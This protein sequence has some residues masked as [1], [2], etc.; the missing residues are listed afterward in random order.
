MAKKRTTTYQY[1]PPVTP[2][3]WSGDEQRYAVR[4]TQLFD[5]LYQKY[6]KLR[7]NAGGITEETDP[8]VPEW[9][10]QENPPAQS[11]TSVN[12]K[13]GAVVL[14]AND[15][16]A[17]PNGFGLGDKGTPCN[18]PNTALLAGWYSLSGAGCI[19]VPNHY[20]LIYGALFVERRYTYIFQTVTFRQVSI[21][22]SSEDGGTT[23][24]EWEYVSPPLYLGVEYPTTE[25][26]Y[27]KIV[28]AKIVN[29]GAL[30]NNTQ[31]YVDGV[32]TSGINFVIELVPM[33]YTSNF[34][35][36]NHPNVHVQLGHDGT[37]AW[38][39]ITTTANMSGNNL[40]V[41][42]KWAK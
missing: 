35:A 15:V 18:D 20:N 41:L 14:N 1:E 28:Y 36:T 12:D 24:S 10:K 5:D 37:Y 16:G 6:G 7:Q 11:V 42:I 30:P 26:W 9:A 21:K 23:W 33:I 19:N 8:T 3:N 39:D 25:R 31:K 40:L 13:T 22:R 27:G 2:R 38:L 34:A 17:A 29:A 32:I 4:L